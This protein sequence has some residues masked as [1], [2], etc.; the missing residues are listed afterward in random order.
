MSE[1]RLLRTLLDANYELDRTISSSHPIP[2]IP[3]VDEDNLN[4]SFFYSYTNRLNFTHE[5][6]PRNRVLDE[7][8]LPF[9]FRTVDHPTWNNW[10]EIWNTPPMIID[11]DLIP[12]PTHE[13]AFQS[14]VF[15]LKIKS[16]YL[17]TKS[18][19]Q[20]IRQ[21][22]TLVFK[23][24]EDPNVRFIVHWCQWINGHDAFLR[25]VGVDSSGQYFPYS[26]PDYPSFILVVPLCLVEVPPSSTDI[27][28]FYSLP[29]ALDEVRLDGDQN[30]A[31]CWVCT[32]M[33]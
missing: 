25:M 24:Y 23:G 19:M 4:L 20:I 16:E 33:F 30:F 3:E 10:S 14:A 27:R 9:A 15:R 8:T 13:D 18:D 5:T 6:L 7:T 17:V 21:G 2:T 12:D 22:T 26:D 1:L 29:I 31:F 32:N 28:L 11:P